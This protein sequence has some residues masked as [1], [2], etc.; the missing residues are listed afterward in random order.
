VTKHTH[1]EAKDVEFDYNTAT[2]TSAGIILVNDFK[3]GWMGPSAV[4]DVT[5]K[6]TILNILPRASLANFGH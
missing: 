2:F 6:R 5:K 3:Y 1:G 4:L